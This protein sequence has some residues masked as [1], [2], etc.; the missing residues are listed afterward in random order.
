MKMV[1]LNSRRR[2]S[3]AA[4]AAVFLLPIAFFLFVYIFRSI[5]YMFQLSAFEWNGINQYKTFIGWDNW[6]DLLQDSKFFNSIRNNLVMMFACLIV[7]IPIGL[8]LAYLIEWV[9]K[10]FRYLKLVYFLPLLMSAVAIGFLFKQLY[11]SRFGLMGVV[12]GWFMEN[13]YN[14]LANEDTA[15]WAVI[16][17]ICW[18]FIPFYMLYFFAGLTTIPEELYE[19][20]IIDGAKRHQ[21]IF[22]ISL[23]LISSVIKNASIL[24]LVGSL[25]YFDLIYVMTEGGPGGATELM[26]TYMYKNAF[27][28]LQMGYGSTVSAAMFIIITLI[29]LSTFKIMYMKKEG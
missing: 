13:P 24:C 22:R 19:A 17:V 7:Q 23:P 3:T 14:L 28:Q 26:A 2:Q 29:S 16:A 6:K 9:D 15:I 18:Q 25:K 4:V 10:R 27:T 21:Y 20:S 8:F 11:D 1:T 12:M 5:F